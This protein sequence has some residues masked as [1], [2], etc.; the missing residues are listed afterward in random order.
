MSS[1]G[2]IDV[3]A[4]YINSDIIDVNEKLTVNNIDIIDLINN[5]FND[6]SGNIQDLSENVIN[7]INDLSLNLI[8][9]SHQRDPSLRFS[10]FHQSLQIWRIFKIDLYY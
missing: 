1:T 10:S 4:N 7:K 2:L 5:N 6:L 9:C 8:E 3:N